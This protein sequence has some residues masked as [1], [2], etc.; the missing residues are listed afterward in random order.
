MHK[1]MCILTRTAP[2]NSIK[3][4]KLTR[5]DD[6][7]GVVKETPGSV[8]RT[9]GEIGKMKRVLF[10]IGEGMQ[11]V[12]RDQ[13]MDLKK[14]PLH[15]PTEHLNE[16]EKERKEKQRRNTRISVRERLHYE[17]E[18]KDTLKEEWEHDMMLAEHAKMKLGFYDK[19]EYFL[20][21]TRAIKKPYT[22]KC[23]YKSSQR[24]KR[25]S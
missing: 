12:T 13:L 22:R 20:E 14:Y 17:N 19:F 11:T 5:L 7:E 6:D 21:L 18:V 10:L 23:T 1:G 24:N 25:T 15:I 16:K 9:L 8:T 4:T 3:V 2:E